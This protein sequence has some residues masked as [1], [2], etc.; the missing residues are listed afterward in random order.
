MR[1]RSGN[2]PYIF[3]LPGINWRAISPSPGSALRPLALRLAY[4]RV[5]ADSASVR[6]DGASVL[7]RMKA[8]SVCSR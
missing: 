3:W 8:A 7:R 1:L 2:G 6:P 5:L 4:P